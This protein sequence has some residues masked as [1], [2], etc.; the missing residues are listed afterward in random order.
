MKLALGTVQFGLKYGLANTSGQVPSHEAASIVRRAR[1][2]GMDTLD[3]AIDYGESESLLGQLGV[4]QWQVITKLPQVPDNCPDVAQWVY[5]QIQQS[6]KRLRVSQLHGVLLH[7]PD[8]LLERVGPALYSSLKSLKSEGIAKNIGVSVHSPDQLRTILDTYVVDLVQ[9]PLNIFDRRLVESGLAKRLNN[10]G[11]EVHTRSA[12]LQGLLLIP[13][14]HRPAKFNRWSDKWEIWDRWLSREGLTPL[15]ACIRYV[16]NI[17][18]IDR[19]VVGVDSLKHLKQ[20]VDAIDCELDSLPELGALDDLRL[21]YPS[22]W[23]QL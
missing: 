4:D 15:E 12:F 8:Q 17:P 1:M 6:I 7:R 9:A 23:D 22:S 14:C 19:V 16:T 20:I 10:S 5:D 21:L 2:W 11:V 3:T 18:V 13:S